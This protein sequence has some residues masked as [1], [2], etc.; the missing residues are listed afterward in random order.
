MVKPTKTG[1]PETASQNGYKIK[2]PWETV[3]SGFKLI[4]KHECFE[5]KKL[6]HQTKWTAPNCSKYADEKKFE[7]NPDH[8]GTYV[9]SK[10]PG[11]F[12]RVVVEEYCPH[13]AAFLYHLKTEQNKL[14]ILR[15]KLKSNFKLLKS[16]KQ[17]SSKTCKI[18]VLCS[19]MV[20][21]WLSFGLLILF[22]PVLAEANQM[23]RPALFGKSQQ[24]DKLIMTNQIAYHFKK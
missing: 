23:D 18:K 14:E 15:N 9:S 2:Y 16:I 22:L 5:F 20:P 1:S 21:W 24:S 6:I 12:R 19:K 3:K 17:R 7:I 8:F 11:C 13:N 10:K 4:D